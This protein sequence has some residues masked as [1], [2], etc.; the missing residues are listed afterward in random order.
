ME[1]KWIDSPLIVIILSQFTA[2]DW[3]AGDESGITHACYYDGRG[4]LRRLPLFLH[5]V[6]LC[7]HAGEQKRG[8]HQSAP[9]ASMLSRAHEHTHCVHTIHALRTA[10]VGVRLRCPVI[11]YSGHFYMS[12]FSSPSLRIDELLSYQR[13]LGERDHF[14]EMFS[15]AAPFTLVNTHTHT[16]CTHIYTHSV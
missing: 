13:D 12:I 8:A 10:F 1:K 2:L 14:S 15:F 11:F 4:F 16:N 5:T 6:Y 9:S 3:S 7:I